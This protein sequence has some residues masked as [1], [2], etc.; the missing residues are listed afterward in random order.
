MFVLARTSNPE[1][2]EVQLAERAGRSVAQAM[3]DGAAAHNAG[4][5][6]LGDV[7]VVIGATHDHGLDLATLNGPV[8]VPGLGA[9]GATGADIARRF[10]GLSGVALPA[11]S[12]SV[13]RAG[14]D[15][16]ALRAAVS[17]AL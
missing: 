6:P 14:P 2:G 13:L 9:Q 12:R 5:V 10:A 16:A 7:G 8:L 1:G 15:P 4:A 3:V 17:A 11:A